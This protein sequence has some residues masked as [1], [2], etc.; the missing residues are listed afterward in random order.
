[1]IKFIDEFISFE[2]IIE[3]HCNYCN[4]PM[5]N[6]RPL[7]TYKSD[8]SCEFYSNVYDIAYDIEHI[9]GYIDKCKL[10]EE[11]IQLKEKFQDIENFEETIIECFNIFD[12]LGAFNINN[13]KY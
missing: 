10:I 5:D 4:C 8:R 7:E 12:D 9:Y 6:W 3:Y 13:F 11:C 1:M 2:R